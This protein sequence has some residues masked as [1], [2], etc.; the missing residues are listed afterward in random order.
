VPDLRALVL[1]AR[2]VEYLHAEPE[3][4]VAREV[5][6]DLV[7]PLQ[8]HEMVADHRLA[9]QRDEG[10]AAVGEIERDLLDRRAVALERGRRLAADPRDLRIDP[11]A[12]ERRRIGQPDAAQ[13]LGA[14]DGRSSA[15]P[16]RWH[17]QR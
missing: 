3:T 14:R 5:R 4:D 10:I 15:L 6:A 17:R 8:P 9:A 16:G 7:E 11:G 12:A 1:G 13:V 2:D